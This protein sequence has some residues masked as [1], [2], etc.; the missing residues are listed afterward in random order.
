MKCSY[1][2]IK[3]ESKG[4]QLYVRCPECGEK[5]YL[6]QNSAWYT[7]D[8]DGKVFPIFVCMA[9]D[10]KCMYEAYVWIINMEEQTA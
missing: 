7:V 1:K 8:P 3:A 2:K 5:Q 6:P 9:R 10:R 4:T